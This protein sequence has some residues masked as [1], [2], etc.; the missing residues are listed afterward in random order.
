MN[1][2]FKFRRLCFLR[3]LKGVTIIRR[4]YWESVKSNISCKDKKK[5]KDK[6]RLC[7]A[8]L[9]SSWH[10]ICKLTRAAQHMQFT[11]TNNWCVYLSISRNDMHCFK[12]AW[13][14][15]CRINLFISSA[16][17]MKFIMFRH[18]KSHKP[19]D[20]VRGIF[21]H[22]MCTFGIKTIIHED[23]DKLIHIYTKYRKDTPLEAREIKGPM[24]S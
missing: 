6:L 9:S 4:G 5:N 10:P 18:E 8:K 22:K 23:V 21:W 17:G 1:I 3:F 11:R 13:R 14:M 24:W 7:C 15:V 2:I 16:S 19:A 12:H 20:L